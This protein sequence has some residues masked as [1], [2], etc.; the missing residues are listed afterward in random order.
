ML[1]LWFSDRF[2]KINCGFVFLHCVLFNVSAFQFTVYWIGATNCQPKSLKTRNAEIR[3]KDKRFDC[4]SCWSY[5]FGRWIVN[6]IMWKTVNKLPK[7]V[8]EKLK[9]EKLSFWF[10]NFEVSSVRPCFYKTN[11][12]LFHWVQ[13]TS[14]SITILTSRWRH[15]IIKDWF[16]NV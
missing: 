16:I 5:H 9:L 12:W 10:L 1:L 15:V 8:F 4:W 2:D 13:H 14:T 6:E 11:I 3:H 7:S